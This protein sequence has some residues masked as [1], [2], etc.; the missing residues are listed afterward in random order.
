MSSDPAVSRLMHAPVP[1]SVLPHYTPEEFKQLL[2]QRFAEMLSKPPD[3]ST[4]EGLARLRE[5]LR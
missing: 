3:V 5:R 4:E 2:D 1:D